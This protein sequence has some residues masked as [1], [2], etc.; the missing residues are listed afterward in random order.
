MT[1]ADDRD[2]GS[3]FAISLPFAFQRRRD[4]AQP[5]R[6]GRLSRGK[7]SKPPY[8]KRSPFRRLHRHLSPYLRCPPA[9][10]GCECRTPPKLIS[11]FAL[12]YPISTPRG[13]RA[14]QTE[15]YYCQIKTINRQ[16]GLTRGG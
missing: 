15:N 3:C 2:Q 9:W 4:P 5:V 8:Y 16:N 12:S 6:R 10:T 1:H 13:K 14:L 7:S 11:S